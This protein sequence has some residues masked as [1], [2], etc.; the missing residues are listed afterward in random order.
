M[1]KIGLAV[2]LLLPR[3]CL[4]ANAQRLPDNAAPDGY[5]ITLAPNFE[6]DNFTGDE[7]IQIR[8]LKPTANLVLN[9]LDIEFQEATI[10]AGGRTQTAKVS[11]DSV[12]QM[13]TLS[14]AK[15][16]A[17]GPAT[18]H[19]RYTGI[20]NDQLRGFYLS[21][22]NGRKYAV[23]QFEATDARR[24]FPGWDEPA[25]KSTFDISLLIDSG[26]TAI[27]NGAQLSDTPGPE[28]GKHTLVLARTPKMSAYLVAM[29]VGDFVCRSGSADAIAVRVCSTPDK[30]PLT[31]FALEAAQQE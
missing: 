17:A 22:A 7:T 25:Y 3:L 11:V 19:I 24:A 30:L 31:G 12:K 6:K 28:A 10:S 5:R 23:T 8:V 1:R 13:A 9:A 21:K 2:I 27:S 18:V 14:L 16:L 26:D 4:M 29:L 15:P 20:L